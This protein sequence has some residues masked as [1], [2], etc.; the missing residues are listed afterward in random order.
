MGFLI[1]AVALAETTAGEDGSYQI[2]WR[3]RQGAYVVEVTG[4]SSACLAAIRLEEETGSLLAVRQAAQDEG[5]PMM[6]GHLEV[7][8]DLLRFVPG[9]PLQAGLRYKA[10]F[11]PSD[12]PEPYANDAQALTADLSIPNKAKG[13]A[14]RLAQVYPTADVLPENLLKFYLHFSAPMSRG[15]IYQ[16][17]HLRTENDEDV[18]LPFLEIDEELWDPT[19]QRLTLF[20]DPGRI[21]REVKPLDDIGPALQAGHAYTLTI[22][23]DWPNA[24]GKPLAASYEKRFRVAEADRSEIDPKAWKMSSPQAGTREI[25]RVQFGEPLDHALSLRLLSVVDSSDALIDGSIKLANKE[26]EWTFEPEK[27]WQTGRYHLHISTLLED[28]AGNNIGKAFEVDVFEDISKR[29]RNT[30]V[31]RAFKVISK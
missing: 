8:G 4:I 11:S 19:M 22:D 26:K 14:T 3:E 20:I 18:E 24:Q 16:Y 29:I 15:G 23:A 1:G 17:I 30:T 2:H 12:L 9:F 27:P 7:S 10:V 25:L 21:K 31:R 5:L 13:P 6:A 28:L